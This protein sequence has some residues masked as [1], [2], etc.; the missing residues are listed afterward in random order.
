MV[1]QPADMATAGP[2]LEKELIE[3][4]RAGLSDLKC[5]RSIDFEPELPRA[6]NGKLYKRRLVERY[7]K[8]HA[9]RIL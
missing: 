4:C 1:V 9:T 8:G 5:P 2:A 7:W 6:E 3:Y